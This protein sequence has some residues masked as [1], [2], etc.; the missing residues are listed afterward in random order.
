M[1]KLKKDLKKGDLINTDLGKDVCEEVVGRWKPENGERYW[2]VDSY[3]GESFHIWSGDSIDKWNY[4]MGNCFQTEK[5]AES[6]KE[7][8]EFI[9]EFE[10]Y[11]RECNGDWNPTD[12]P[13]V[14]KYAIYGYGGVF[15]VAVCTCMENSYLFEGRETAQGAI[16]KFGGKLRMLSPH[17]KPE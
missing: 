6:Y 16:D 14:C 2:Y 13:E 9:A 17:W 1:Y 3:W 15:E 7:R 10:E 4:K 8:I 12:D 11:W 5:E